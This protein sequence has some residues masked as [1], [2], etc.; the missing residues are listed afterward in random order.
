MLLYSQ[1]SQSQL[2]NFGKFCNGW[3]IEVT[4][5]KTQVV[6]I[7]EN[8]KTLKPW[9]PKFTLRKTVDSYWFLV[10]VLHLE[11]VKYRAIKPEKVKQWGTIWTH[12]S[13]INKSII[14]YIKTHHY[15][16]NN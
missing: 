10:I 4:E 9:G 8:K 15:H 7:G 5:N 14:K 2:K 12:N 16:T 6:T 3:S 1:A 13:A 11:L